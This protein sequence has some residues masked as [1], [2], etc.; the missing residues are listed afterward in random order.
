MTGWVVYSKRDCTQGPASLSPLAHASIRLTSASGQAVVESLG[1]DGGFVADVPGDGAISAVAVTDGAR[2]SVTP[3]VEPGRPYEIA[4]GELTQQN[5]TLVIG[6]GPGNTQPDP[7]S[8]AANIYSVLDAGAR[9]AKEASP[10][11]LPKVRVR[12]R[13]AGD[14]TGWLGDLTPS[15]YDSSTDEIQVGGTLHQGRR[16]EWAAFPLLHEYA[17]HVHKYVANPPD[18]FG[19][20]G[21]DTTHPGSPA[22]PWS[23]GFANFFAALGQSNPQL[24]LGCTVRVD[25]S[26]K[27]AVAR[28]NAT[29]QLA[30][31][32]PAGQEHLAQYNETAVAGS[33]WSL[34]H[35][36]GS[37]VP[38]AGFATLLDALHT[39]KAKYHAPR[40]MREV[41][42][43]V[44]E[45]AD[46]GS[47]T[48]QQEIGNAFDDHRLRWGFHFEETSQ[49]VNASGS[50]WVVPWAVGGF[51]DMPRAGTQDPVQA[52]VDGAFLG[53]VGTDANGV[54][55]HHGQAQIHGPLTHTRHDECWEF[56][57]GRVLDANAT[58][59]YSLLG[60]LPYRLDQAHRSG[61]TALGVVFRCASPAQI[62]AGASRTVTI[63]VGTG[64]WHRPNGQARPDAAQPLNPR[65]VTVTVPAVYGRDPTP[66]DIVPVAEIDALGYCRTLVGPPQDC[67]S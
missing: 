62:C 14:L 63:R 18:A 6:G 19:S 46:G 58:V 27:P 34:V 22:L 1:T 60:T 45:F 13:Y 47:E 11:P 67:G 9:L 52:V 56:I 35:V 64:I 23:E 43:A 66:A 24:T 29:D 36:L 42:D 61:R 32:P 3:D 7:A 10:V 2:I 38:A 39:F 59:L 57:R 37:N 51:C 30:A 65:T 8:G 5:Q 26:A 17:H 20:H 53:P 44:T 50:G 54:R 21:F 49:T 40:D 55:N 28:L 41:R 31:M 12:W 16:D 48:L 15:Q 33:L 4:L 25:L